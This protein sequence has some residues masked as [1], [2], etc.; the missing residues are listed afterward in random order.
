[1]AGTSTPSNPNRPAKI[2]YRELGI[3]GTRLFAGIV[4]EESVPQLAGFQAYKTFQGMRFDATCAAL[5]R[6]IELPTRAARWFVNPGSDNP[7]AEEMAEF[8]YDMLYEFGTQSM[9]DV[10]RIALTMLPF[11]FSWMEICYALVENGPWKG[12]IGWDKLAYRSAATKWRWNMDYVGDKRQLVSI[13]QLAPPYYEQVEIPKSKC[14]LFVNDLEGDQYDGWS[15]FRPAWKDYFIRDALYRIRAIGLERAYMGIPVA[16]LPEAFG[17]DLR[18]LARQIVETLRV[19][20]Q[21]GVI[22]PENLGLEVLHSDLQTAA[23]TEAIQ[24]HNRQILLSALAE[25]LDLGAKNVGSYA[26]SSDQSDLFQMCV[27]TKA[28]YIAEVVNLDPGLPTL[29]NFNFPNVETADMPK[30]EHGDI[31]QRSLDKLGRTLMALGQWGFLTPDDATEDRLRQMLDLPE[32][33]DNVTDR[34]LVDLIQQVFP[35]QP[36]YG[37][38][39]TGVRLPSPLAT[40]AKAASAKATQSGPPKNT[41]GPAPAA[42]NAPGGRGSASQTAASQDDADASGAMGEYRQRYLNG[43]ASFAEVLVRRRWE[44]PTGRPTD[45]QRLAM[46]ATERFTEA[47]DEFATS[48]DRRPPRPRDIIWNRR[49]PYEVRGSWLAGHG[50]AGRERYSDPTGRTSTPDVIESNR[51]RTIVTRQ[52]A[53]ARQHQ[54]HLAGL[55]APRKKGAV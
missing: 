39:H 48:G 27:N 55:L 15:I 37:H 23:M 26:L 3:S 52:M 4:S 13:T 11:G 54:A 18:D 36:E 31:G 34:N 2:D 40:Q 51:Q 29:I 35:T 6:A 42:G 19:D 17:D 30:L 25:F 49:R 5:Y 8:A 20:E 41:T 12:K 22:R 47:L 38:V 7:K 50:S 53:R 43:L 9:D 28:N 32:R 44:R 33:Q 21:A 45:G 16:V 14:L 10:L 46:R 24:Y 1:M